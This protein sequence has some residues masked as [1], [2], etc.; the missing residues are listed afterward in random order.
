M[1]PNVFVKHWQRGVLFETREVHNVW[2]DYGAQ[3]L[4]ELATGERS[5]RVCY[6]GLGLG[7]IYRG[8]D[9]TQAPLVSTY[10]AGYA[11][12]LVPP[13]FTPGA[14]T[15]GN[16]YDHLKPLSPKVGTLELPLKLSGGA[17]PY[18]GAPTDVW[19]AG[20][21]NVYITH[22]TTQEATVHAIVDPTAGEYLL[23]LFLEVPVAEAALFT[24]ATDVNAPYGDVVA[25]V[26]FQPLVLNANSL[27]EF[28]WRA[29]FVQ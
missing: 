15:A 3:Y 5:D 1:T 17:A 25:Y 8:A 23:G 6:F 29:R 14:F 20:P 28:V 4:C 11:P 18:P 16:E 21:P 24:S 26:N 13:D 9:A 7:G 27:V 10:P 2:T 22:I 12:K 19:V